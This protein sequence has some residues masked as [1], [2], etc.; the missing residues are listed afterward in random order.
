MPK[1]PKPRTAQP[2]VETGKTLPNRVTS[3]SPS[4]QRYTQADA[5][6]ELPPKRRWSKYLLFMMLFIFGLALAIGVWDARNISA[7]S[8]KLFGD[9]NILTLIKGG[10]LGTT[11]TGRTNILIAGYSADDPGPS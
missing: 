6:S 7:A 10:G 1:K 2:A 8:Q 5:S 9:G 11:D 4:R 3:Y